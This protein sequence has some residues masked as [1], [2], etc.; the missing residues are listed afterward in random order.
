MAGWETQES[1][2]VKR[3]AFPSS[4]ELLFLIL[5]ITNP[6]WMLFRSHWFLPFTDFPSEDL[7][8]APWG[9]RRGQSCNTCFTMVYS[10]YLTSCYYWDAISTSPLDSL[11]ILPPPLFTVHCLPIPTSEGSHD[12]NLSEGA[13]VSINLIFLYIISYKVNLHTFYT[14]EILQINWL[15][16]VRGKNK[17][18]LG[19]I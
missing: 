13:V 12:K 4:N 19:Y 16:A 2:Q 5:L 9:P 14:M 7:W 11:I 8:P 6:D 3:S 18:L 10:F 15:K 17:V 1:P